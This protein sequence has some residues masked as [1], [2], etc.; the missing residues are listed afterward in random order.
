MVP[1]PNIPHPSAP[2]PAHEGWDSFFSVCRAPG[3][4]GY[5]GTAVYCR[6]PLT[7]LAAEEGVTGALAPGAGVD[8]KGGRG[9]GSKPSGEGWCG[10]SGADKDT[11]EEDGEHGTE[12]EAS[13]G[14]AEGVVAAGGGGGCEGESW[15]GDGGGGE[16]A[17]CTGRGIQHYGDMC[18]RFSPQR[19]AEL[20]A[21]GRALVVDLGNFVLFNLYVPALSSAGGGGDPG[22]VSGADPR[23]ESPPPSTPTRTWKRYHMDLRP[24]PYDRKKYPPMIAYEYSPSQP[25]T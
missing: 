3:K 16:E 19:M 17:G 23:A 13:A 8:A 5:A 12:D 24:S 18:E 10:V 9:T 22:G 20:D 2:G 4:G 14:D 1:T 6:L 21:E 11:C 25:V 7:V 15:R